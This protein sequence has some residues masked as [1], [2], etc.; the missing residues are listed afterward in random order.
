MTS[1]VGVAPPETRPPDLGDPASTD[2]RA[3]WLVPLAVVA[4]VLLRLP[5]LWAPMSPD[6]G[7]F[8]AVGAQ[9]NGRGTSLYGSYWVDR[10]P[11]LITVYHL[12]AWAGGLTALR[13]IGCVAAALT[14]WCCAGAARN[15]AGRRAQSCTALVAAAM[16]ASPILGVVP[17]NGELLATPF[18]AGSAFAATSAVARRHSRTGYL[19]T[20][21]TA[22]L[23]SVGALMVKQN[24]ADGVVF[25]ALLWCTAWLRGWIDR[26]RF[27]KLLASFVAGALG[28]L[29]LVTLWIL[30]RG[31]SPGGVLYAM[32]PF[33][34][35]A[36]GV[37]TARSTGPNL[38]RLHRLISEWI[39]SGIPVVLVAFAVQ[40]ARVRFNR[41]AHVALLG[42]AAYST[43]SVV[44]G[45]NYWNHYLVETIVPAALCAGALAVDRVVL[46]RL[47]AALLVASS[48]VAWGI[49]LVAWTG[50]GGLDAGRSIAAAARP[51]DTI[52]VAFG[53]ADLVRATGLRSPYPYLWSLPTHTLDP[54]LSR[55]AATMRGPAAPTWL[56]VRG[57]S[58]YAY[59]TRHDGALIRSRYHAVTELCNRTVYLRNGVTRR[60]PAVPSSCRAPLVPAFAA[61]GLRTHL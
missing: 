21:L 51:H 11:L 9:W 2:A 55:L 39:L 57:P 37:M 24:M 4:V 32:Y 61:T 3:G 54:R 33:R 41:P 52:V 8:L 44:A 38:A 48:L 45:G 26:R 6:E 47:M 23:L 60:T 5:Y 17:V 30:L 46:A 49:G 15:I 43:V 58:T 31:T 19:A 7:G 29:A 36:A 16:L 35:K 18:V 10:P 56:V 34:I 1:V 50:S 25:T 13:L 59:L 53:D 42:M 12:A 28:A 27:W 14:V 40:L 22:G 20:A